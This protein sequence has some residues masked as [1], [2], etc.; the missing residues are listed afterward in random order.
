[1]I[2]TT[3]QVKPFLKWAGGKGQL[4]G[5]IAMHLPSAF[6]IGRIK[7][8]FEP[9]LGGG[10]L[11]FWLSEQ[12]DFESVYLYEI[13]PSVNICYQVIQ[14]NVGKLVKELSHL[15]LEYLSV[16]EKGREKLYY[17][18]R[19]EFNAFLRRKASNSIIRR[20]ALLIFLNKT[21]FNGLYR[22]NSQ[23]E[24]NVPFGWYKNPTICNEGNLY[25]ANELLQ[26]AEVFGGDFAQ[27][28]EYADK[29]SFVYFD[30]PYRPISMTASFTSY[31]KDAFDD[32][33]QR[34]LRKVYGDLDKKGAFVMLSN[35]DPKNVDPGDNFFDDLYRGYHIERLN[36]T[37]LINCNAERRGTITE[38][39]VMNY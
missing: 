13:N 10:A 7:K 3:R 39:L 36:A 1:M 35:S 19:E 15:E 38:I 4:I 28:L 2:T 34:R 30:P 29:D 32:Q 24:F 23:G 17:D 6:K 25:G 11:F 12:Y 9:F 37:R 5:Q 31:S 14:K 26:K 18:K 16:S 27:C 8:Y 20:A 33:E 22:V 21:C